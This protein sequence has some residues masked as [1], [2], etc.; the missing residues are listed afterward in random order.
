MPPP[1]TGDYTRLLAAGQK[2]VMDIVAQA[3][4]L[5]V[6]SVYEERALAHQELQKWPASPFTLRALCSAAALMQFMTFEAVANF[7]A[8][9]AAAISTGGLG[10]PP[11]TRSLH[12]TELDFLLE[13]KTSLDPM[14][15][16]IAT[17]PR[18]YAASLDRL[19]TTPR[20]LGAIVGQERVVDKGGEGWQ[21]IC[22]LKD[23]R[24]RLTHP[25][26]NEQPERETMIVG[27]THVFRGA[28]ALYWYLQQIEPLLVSMQGSPDGWIATT[29]ITLDHLR[30]SAGYSKELFLASYPAP[31]AI[32]EAVRNGT[33]TLG[34]QE[35]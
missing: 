14:T 21:L 19:A 15:G 1:A 31:A 9:L 2:T 22:E 23:L 13:Q 25:Q 8:V 3:N 29:W 26:V 30:A 28:R 32:A 20:L 35:V 10:A 7:M 16:K 24:D 27:P 17:R 5:A 34:P 18:A 4:N 33:F 11:R 6:A 12:S